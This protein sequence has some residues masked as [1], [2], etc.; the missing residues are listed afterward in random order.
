MAF[1]TAMFVTFYI[2]ERVSRAKLLQFVS[3]VNKVIFWLTSFIIDYAMFI[4][5]SVVFLGVLASYDKE[6]Y[7]TDEELVRNLL[8]LLAFGFAVLPYTYVWS[9]VFQIPSLGLVR[10]AIGYIITGVFCYLAYFVFNNEYLGLAYLAEPSNWIFLIF[11]HYSLARGMSNLNL[12]QATINSCEKRCSSIPFCKSVGMESLCVNLTIACNKT[13]KSVVCELTDSCCN[14]N[15]YSF[16]EHGI[17]MN[18]SALGIIGIVSFIVLFLIEYKWLENLLSN[19]K[20][21]NR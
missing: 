20:I 18:L 4:A 19:I 7:S 6:G 1:V 14:R 9:F 3:G 21:G 5:I 8:V 10:L 16:D 12:V 17:G 11:P 15:F 2:K 13:S